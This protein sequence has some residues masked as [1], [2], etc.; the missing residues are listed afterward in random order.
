MSEDTPKENPPA[1]VFCSECGTKND[2]VAK[3]CKSCGKPLTTEHR[4]GAA[5]VRPASLPPDVS[6]TFV[7]PVSSFTGPIAELIAQRMLFPPPR[8]GL[9]AILDQ[10]EILRVLGGGGMGLVLLARDSGTGRDVAIK[11]VKSDLVTNQNVVHRFL[12]EAG[13]LKRLRHTNV[14]PVQEISDR[15]EGPYFVMPYFEKGSLANR[16]KPGQP[17]DPESILDIAAQVAEGLSFAHRSG[18]IHRDLKPANILLTADGKACLA[19]FGLARTFFNDSIVDVENRN[20]EGTTPYM[21]PA[22]AAGDAED[23]RCDIYSFGALLYE[24]LTGHP[25]YKGRGTKEILDQIITGPPKPITSLNPVAD[26]SLV[27]VA[28]GCMARELRERYA[29]MRDVLKDLQR[30]KE[31]KQPIGQRKIKRPMRNMISV[32][33]HLFRGKLRILWISACVAGIALL[34]WMI[35]RERSPRSPSLSPLTVEDIKALTAAGVANDVII[36]DMGESKAVYSPADITAVQQA[37]PPVDQAV[38]HYMKRHTVVIAPQPNPLPSVSNTSA[39]NITTLAGQVGVGGYA[40]GAGNQAQ[41]RLPNSVAVDSTG[42][43]YVADTANNTI[44]KSTPNGIV[45]TLAGISG[46]HGSADGIG[47]NARFWAPF[48]IAVDRSG[49]VY[50]ADTANNT[51]RKI[52]PNGVVS[53]LAGLAGHPGNKDGIGINAR[54]RN[55]WGVAVDDAGNV[56]VAD[57]SND[58]IRKIT[59]TGVVSTLAGQAGMSGSVDGFGSQARFNAPYDVAADNAGNVYVSDSANDTIRKITPSGVVSTLAGLPGYAGGTDGNG[60]DARF[61]NPQGLA[62][63]SKEN[64]YVA[65]SGNNTVRK[66][67]PMGVVTT[68]AGLAGTPGPSDGVGA[69]ARF[70]SPGGAAVDNAGNVY[71]ADVNNHTVRKITLS[72]SENP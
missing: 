18:I 20:W 21:S 39:L 68:L 36:E 52:T 11:L 16:I 65:D 6:P 69:D 31:N 15:A 64:I 56:F 9:L 62:V 1:A 55:P 71:V 4:L 66:I 54:F 30:I 12:K 33:M 42:N 57:M 60:K 47:G 50:V 46:S 2:G 27:A 32:D 35:W 25:P 58:T 3:F 53:T 61:W 13:H 14:V 24:M 59:P 37:N 67:T 40:D 49:N 26:H 7:P 23:T 28:E 22:V 29:D 8:S 34:G 45:S 44:R 41:F 72:K 63:D 43:V 70:N 51:I 48:G 19:D 10:F 38:I 5:A 17:L